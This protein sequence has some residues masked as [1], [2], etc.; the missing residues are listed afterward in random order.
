[1]EIEIQEGFDR[2]KVI[3]ECPQKTED[4][5]RI[6]KSLCGFDQKLSC[7]KN[8][9]TYLIDKQDILYFE[10]VDKHCFLYTK[11]DFYETPL[12][13]YEVEE[14]LAEMGFI[15]IT[16][17]QVLNIAKIESLCPDFG[18]RIEVVMENDYRLLVSRQYAKTLK[19][20]IGLK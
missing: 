1:M 4:I 11:N 10:S 19:K 17:S 15:R 13:L 6:E 16:K 14:M 8:D 20:R 5:C 12:K 2:I 18:G 7:T 9:M 3:I